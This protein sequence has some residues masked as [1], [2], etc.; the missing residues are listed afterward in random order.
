MATLTWLGHAS[1][2]LDTDGGKRI[3][4]DPWLS[5]PTCPDSEREPERAD[6]IAVT[7]GHGDH[8]GDVAAL[9]QKLGLQ[10]DRDGRADGRGSR[11]TASRRTRSSRSTRA[12]RSSSTASASR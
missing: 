11:R 9:Q 1:F 2:R 3:Y 8:V 12:G 6:V 7:H 5:G 10:G 4:V